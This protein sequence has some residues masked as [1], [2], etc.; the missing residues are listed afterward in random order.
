MASRPETTAIIIHCSGTVP[1]QDIGAREIDR[2]HRMRGMFRI[3]YHWVIRR[4]GT[5][6]KRR[7]EHMI[8]AHSGAGTDAASVGVCLVGGVD[9]DLRPEDNFTSTQ[10]S[11][12]GWL[13]LAIEDRYPDVLTVIGH[14]DVPGAKTT[15]PS[16]DVCAWVRDTLP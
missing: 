9:A 11:A 6:E 3:A 5:V 16:F 15:C 10:M 8:G 13:V 4:D 7:D 2:L 1:T 12:L 14:R